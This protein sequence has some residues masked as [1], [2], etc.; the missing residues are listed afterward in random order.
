MTR[1]GFF[2]CGCPLDT[3][4]QDEISLLCAKHSQRPY[5]WRSPAIH[6]SGGGMM[7]DYSEWARIT[8]IELGIAAKPDL[9]ALE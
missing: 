6:R 9:K 5:G 2:L 8:D 7:I 4:L 1:P 3:A